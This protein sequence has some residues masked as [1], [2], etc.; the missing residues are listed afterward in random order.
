M[1][2]SKQKKQARLEQIAA[3]VVQQP[4]ALTPN[5][6]A[7]TLRVARSTISYD[8]VTLED[9][10]VLLAEDERARLSLFR[11]IFGK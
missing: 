5:D 9:K 8:L 4:D 3:L 11:R 2:G 10:G 7:K 6:L 1:F